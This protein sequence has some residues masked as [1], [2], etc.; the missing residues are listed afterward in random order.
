ME[1]KNYL[2]EE[3]SE[4]E[5]SYLKKI[6]IS[7]KNDYLKKNYNYLNMEVSNLSEN[8]VDDQYSVLELVI[9]KYEAEIKSAIEFEKVFS[10]PKLYKI[11]KA[12][13]LEEKMVLF[14]LFKENRSIRATAK[15]LKI[16]KNTVLAKRNRVFNIIKDLLG[17]DENV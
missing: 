8:I 15:E 17:D 14:S 9:E 13:S 4:E 10:Y 5:I 1:R 6:V 7:A 3:L 11:V 2:L 16:D 12:L